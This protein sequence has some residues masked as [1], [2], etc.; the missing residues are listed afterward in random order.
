MNK[1]ALTSWCLPVVF[2]LA[3]LAVMPA[4]AVPSSDGVK[5]DLDAT[6]AAIERGPVDP[7]IDNA[8]T[9]ISAVRIQHTID[10]LVSFHTR[11][12]L[13]SEHTLQHGDGFASGPGRECRRRLD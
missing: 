3:A 8:L 2:L 10:T 13:S 11:N 6:G 1:R 9:H 12:T 5:R 7:R 4:G